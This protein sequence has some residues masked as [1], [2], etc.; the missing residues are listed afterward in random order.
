MRQIITLQTCKMTLGDKIL[1]A[2]PL[3]FEQDIKPK[4]R[5]LVAHTNCLMSAAKEADT[6]G[7]WFEFGVYS[8]KTLEFLT[9][10]KDKVYGFD[11]FE[12]LPEEWNEHNEKGKFDTQGVP[13][14]EPNEKMELVI[15][16]FDETLPK[17]LNETKIERVSLLHLDADLYSSTKCV[18]DNM[19]PYFSKQCVLVFDEFFNYPDWEHHEYKAFKEFL[20]Q[21]EDKI[22]DVE[23]LGFSDTRYHPAA[24]KVIFK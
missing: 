23:Y 15:G 7:D 22:E 20:N 16:W 19:K 11:S 6:D 5:Y 24:F 21:M 12:G 9:T 3:E 10:L 2:T 13:P 4:M 18:F 17:F 1:G 8:G 14:F